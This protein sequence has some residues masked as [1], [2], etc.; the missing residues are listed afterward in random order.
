MTFQNFSTITTNFKLTSNASPG[1]GGG[2]G[3]RNSRIQKVR[4]H[5]VQGGETYSHNNNMLAHFY[6]VGE[7]DNLCP[8]EN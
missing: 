5:A 2:P 3:A 4:T 6:S 8:D 7:S 1:G